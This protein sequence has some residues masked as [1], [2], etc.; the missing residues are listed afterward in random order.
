MIDCRV[1]W[2][3]RGRG[4]EETLKE[5]TIRIHSIKFQGIKYPSLK[6]NIN[7]Y[8]DIINELRRVLRESIDP[9]TLQSSD[10]FFKQGEQAKVYGVRMYEIGKIAKEFYKEV[11]GL[12]KVEIFAL[13]ETLWQSGYFEEAVVACECAYSLRT[14]YEPEDFEVFEYWLSSYVDNWASCDTLCNHTIGTFVEQYPQYLSRLKAW[15]ASE[16][17]WMR[18]GAAVTLIIPARKGL[19][20]QDILEIATTLL[21]DRDD[22]VQKGYGWMLKAASDSYQ[23]K[24]F[25]FV[26]HHKATMPRTALRYA[27]EKM[28]AE[29]R[30]EAMKK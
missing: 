6:T 26:I 18:R 19:F 27:I 4:R 23:G 11:R 2:T 9:K 20:Y 15:T 3:L 12:P 13:C 14:Q 29:M 7:M 21:H 5:E 17:R 16:N 8:R 28:P 1:D 30:K 25:D 10:R 24:V 22:L